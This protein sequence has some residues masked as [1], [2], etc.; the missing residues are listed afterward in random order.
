MTF[1]G[2]SNLQTNCDGLKMFKEVRT[3]TTASSTE[4]LTACVVGDTCCRGGSDGLAVL[5]WAPRVG[6]VL[7]R[8]E[9]SFPQHWGE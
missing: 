2:N 7:A 6:G 3:D 9:E 4:A 8:P 1:K 5:L